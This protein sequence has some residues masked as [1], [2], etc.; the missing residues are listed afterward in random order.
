MRREEPLAPRHEVAATRPT[1]ARVAGR[2][3]IPTGFHIAKAMATKSLADFVE[4]ITTDHL[5]APSPKLP[6]RSCHSKATLPPDNR[7][8][9]SLIRAIRA[10]IGRYRIS[11]I[12]LDNR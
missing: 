11:A 8:P 1:L 10:D 7:Q 3:T 4:A 2:L 9:T 5:N 6:G 12:P